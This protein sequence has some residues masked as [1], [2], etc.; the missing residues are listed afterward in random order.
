MEW[1][2]Q[3]IILANRNFS[4][5]KVI[6]TIFT[7]DFGLKSGIYSKRCLFTPGNIVYARWKARLETHLGTWKI[8]QLEEISSFIF[9]NQENLILLNSLLILLIKSLPEGESKKQVYQVAIKILLGFKIK[10]NNLYKD[11]VKFDLLLLKELGFGLDLKKCASTGST[12]DLFYISPKTGRAV[13]KDAGKKYHLKLILLP[14]ALKNAESSQDATLTKSDFI[15]CIKVINYFYKRFFFTP[16][17][18]EFPFYREMLAE[19]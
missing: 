8:E 3:G 18:I 4:E 12:S 16:L 7:K 14:T 9:F 11:F 13:C 6:T 10:S 15:E 17:G 19:L 5:S 2:S 1:E